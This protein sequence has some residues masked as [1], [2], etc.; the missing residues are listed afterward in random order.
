[1]LKQGLGVGTY[2]EESGEKI[3]ESELGKKVTDSRLL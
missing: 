2:F 1:M 3:E